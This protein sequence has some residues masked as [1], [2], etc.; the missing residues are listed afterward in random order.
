MSRGLH[1]GDVGPG[2]TVLP[3]G[4]P[5]HP[6]L[7]RSRL[8][9]PTKAKRL[10]RTTVRGYQEA[11]GRAGDG[12]RAA[13][14]GRACPGRGGRRCR[15]ISSAVLHARQL[16]VTTEGQRLH[17]QLV[18]RRLRYDNVAEA[19]RNSGHLHPGPRLAARKRP[20]VDHDDDDD[21]GHDDQQGDGAAVTK[22]R[23]DDD[24]DGR[25][26]LTGQSL[27]RSSPRPS[28]STLVLWS[29]PSWSAGSTGGSVSTGAH[30]ASRPVDDN[31]GRLGGQRHR[32]PARRRRCV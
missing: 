30:A 29:S 2:C 5:G 18:S 24:H 21:R 26:E 12:R 3:T 28:C 16:H 9:T 15:L 8:G 20:A 4:T 6:G 11:D 17:P 25:D 31:A 10:T 13:A 19:T 22:A 23:P 32:R 1:R 7:H 27:R 14:S